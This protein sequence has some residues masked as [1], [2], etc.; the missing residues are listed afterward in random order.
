MKHYKHWLLYLYPQAWRARYADEFLAL[1]EACPLSL[2]TIWD[3]CLGAIDARLHLETVTGRMFP[4]MNRLRTTAVIVF[5]AYIGFVVAGLGFGKLVEYDD[6]QELLNSNT[7]V[8]VSYYAL[9]MGAFVALAAVLVGGLP[10]AFAAAR[11]AIAAKRWRLLLLFAVPPL[12]LALWLSNIFIGDARN[13]NPVPVLSRP[14]LERI[15]EAIRFVG[16]FGLAAIISTAAI[17]ILINRSEISEKMFRFARI[18]AIVTALAMVVMFVAVLA[19]G[20]VGMAAN[21]ALFA[22][23]EGLMATNTTLSWALIVVMMAIA[24][25]VAVAA[26]IRGRRPGAGAAATNQAIAGQAAS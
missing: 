10:L 18:P 13:P 22:G 4:F 16:L 26:L 1:L 25:V 19:Y 9:Y 2:W 24:T 3:V 20:L 5:C 8:A 21:P 11:Y 15:V 12:S 17:C 14:L 7:G 23:D 6:F